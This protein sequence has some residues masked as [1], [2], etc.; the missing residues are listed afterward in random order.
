MQI[1]A[2][3]PDTMFFAVEPFHDGFPAPVH[4]F[5][6]FKRIAA[7]E[8]ITDVYCVFLNLTLSLLGAC[9]LPD[10][11]CMPGANSSW[12]IKPLLEERNIKLHVT[13][14]PGG[15]IVPWTQKEFLHIAAGNCSTVFT[16]IEEVLQTVPGSL[17]HPVVINTDLYTYSEKLRSSK[18]QI[19][20]CAYNSVRKGFPLMADALNRLTSEFHLHLI[21]DW[22]DHL[23]LLT[24]D[25][26]T[27]YGVMSPESLAAIYAKSHV[28]LNCSTVD[29][30]A[31]DGFPTTSAVDA[32]S[33]GC[34]LVSTNP[35][36]DRF[37]LERGTDFIEVAPNGQDIADA[38]VWVKENFGE[39]MRIG[40]NGSNKIKRSFDAK[41]IV[42]SKLGCIFGET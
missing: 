37:I 26:Y 38:L 39:A 36:N 1:Y 17:Y 35:R 18:I 41:H 16:N 8:G 42:K 32:M 10:G 22:D 34:V 24:N 2:Q 19:T 27:Y 14:Y 9:F 30:Y 6:D 29:Q 5:S 20:F 11:S 12:N 15:G 28:F 23:H 21:G 25:N 33:T 13:L 40:I 4:P 7:S 31:L 3:K